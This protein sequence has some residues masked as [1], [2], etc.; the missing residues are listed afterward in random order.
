[1]GHYLISFTLFFFF[2]RHWTRLPHTNITFVNWMWHLY[3]LNTIKFVGS[4]SSAVK[5]CNLVVVARLT[6]IQCIYH[7]NCIGGNFEV[8]LF[9]HHF[10]HQWFEMICFTLSETVADASHSHTHTHTRPI[11]FIII[12]LPNADYYSFSHSFLFFVS[13]FSFIRS[14][15][16]KINWSIYGLFG[17]TIW[18]VNWKKHSIGRLFHS[19]TIAHCTNHKIVHIHSEWV[20]VP[21][22]THTYPLKSSMCVC[23]LRTLPCGMQRSHL[24]SIVHTQQ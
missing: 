5:M 6:R 13:N 11:I 8:P 15:V 19:R 12:F 23:A 10:L 9:A 24:N 21:A 20:H 18:L 16:I 17:W 22:Y 3:F 4:T 14:I 1:M 7:D 2:L